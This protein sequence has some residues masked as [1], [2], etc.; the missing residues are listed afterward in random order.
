MWAASWA[1]WQH[2]AQMRGAMC[3]LGLFPTRR[4]MRF[5]LYMWRDFDH[6]IG[7]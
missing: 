4:M 2:L 5:H 7:A 1:S 3:P 6:E